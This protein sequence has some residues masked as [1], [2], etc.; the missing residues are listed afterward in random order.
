MTEILTPAAAL[1]AM[2]RVSPGWLALRE[3]AD[4]AARSDDLVA[5][6]ARAPSRGGS[7]LGSPALNTG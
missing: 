6:A 7:P 3:A 2:P 4:A 1:A 5:A